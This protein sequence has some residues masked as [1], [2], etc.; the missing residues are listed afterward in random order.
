M[1][2]SFDKI[3]S[4]GKLEIN[5]L[6]GPAQTI[7][8]GLGDSI[9]I[10]R[11]SDNQVVLKE[12]KVSRHHAVINVSA[13]GVIISDLGSMNGSFLNGR[14]ISIPENLSDGDKL[15]IGHTQ[16][17]VS[18]QLPEGIDTQDADETQ[19]ETMRRIS[20]TVLVADIKNYTSMS[21]S[22]QM[23]DVSKTL[24]KWLSEVSVL[25]SD[26]GGTVDKYIGDAVMAFWTAETLSSSKSARN[27]LNTAIQIQQL[28]KQFSDS[29][30]KSTKYTWE[31]SLSMNSGEALIGS[32]GSRAKRDFTIIGDTVN[33]AFRLE[34]LCK[35][36]STDLLI[37]AGS[38]KLLKEEEK[39]THL[40]DEIVEG[41][42]Q[43]ISVY[44]LS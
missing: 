38:A 4:V 10:G 24:N 9:S 12:S 42:K 3:V 8:L 19:A 36:Y 40:G 7:N 35:K 29:F 43:P 16:I 28:T 39:F 15:I 37:G 14:Q 1:A 26:N 32:V 22:I 5:R 30:Q 44:C 33:T 18:L 11:T 41:K 27:A 34:S 13:L 2:E 23:E 6:D 25:V 17:N 21:E 31:A 20:V